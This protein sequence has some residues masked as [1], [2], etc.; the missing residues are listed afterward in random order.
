VDS[1]EFIRVLDGPTDDGGGLLD[2][3]CAMLGAGVRPTLLLDHAPAHTLEA[4]TTKGRA[5]RACIE[6]KATIVEDFPPRSADLNPIEKAWFVAEDHLWK[7]YTWSNYTEFRAALKA[8]WRAAIT[9]AFCKKLVGGLRQTYEVCA[10]E[11]GKEVK[12]WGTHATA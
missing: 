11:G 7:N 4:H 10:R 9:P 6:A 5:V 2:Q 1:D 8:A 12:G 3:A